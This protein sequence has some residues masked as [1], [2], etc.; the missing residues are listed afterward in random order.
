MREKMYAHRSKEANFEMADELGLSPEAKSNFVYA[1][2]EVEFGVEIDPVT[3]KVLIM[4]VN[5]ER[6]V[7]PVSA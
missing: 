7:M 3:G 2:S 4:S 6:L 1:L 5:G